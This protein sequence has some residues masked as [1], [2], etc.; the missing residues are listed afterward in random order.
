MTEDPSGNERAKFETWAVVELMGHTTFAGLVAEVE[1]AG[2]GFLRLTVPKCQDRA[3]F[4]KILSPGSIYGITPCT[5]E[6][7]RRMAASLRRR[8]FQ[9]IDVPIRDPNPALPGFLSGQGGTRE[10]EEPDEDFEDDEY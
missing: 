5:E 1:I 4:D 10:E 7:A 3:G 2:H 9:L 8:P 6:F